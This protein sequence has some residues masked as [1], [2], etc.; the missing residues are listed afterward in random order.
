MKLSDVMGD[1]N[2][3]KCRG[4]PFEATVYNMTCKGKKTEN[5]RA[6]SKT[7]LILVFDQS[8][9]QHQQKNK[10]EEHCSL[11]LPVDFSKEDV[12][13]VTKIAD[14]TLGKRYPYVCL[15]FRLFNILNTDFRFASCSHHTIR[16]R[17][18][19]PTSD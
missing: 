7:E 13:K 3:H 14:G 15:W 9:D 11:E 12:A 17:R 8:T 6:N 16:A 5:F 19:S 2:A 4:P 1:G 18:Q 10:T